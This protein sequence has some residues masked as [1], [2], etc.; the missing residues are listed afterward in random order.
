M[1]E[2]RPIPSTAPATGA[3]EIA[4]LRVVYAGIGDDL[5][6]ERGV[7][8]GW[9]VA[10][11]ELLEA[12]PGDGSVDA[13]VAAFADA[14]AIVTEGLAIT[15]E[16]LE[17]LPRLRAV[18]LQSIGTNTVDLA[19]AAE[20]GVAVS[21]APGFCVDEV[22]THT[23]AMILDLARHV[24]RFDRRVRAGAWDP[25]D[26]SLPMPRRLRGQRVG[27][28][29]FGA[30]PRAVAPLLH[31]FGLEVAVWAPTWSAEDLAAAGVTPVGSLDELLATS[32]VVSLHCPLLPS[33]HHLVGE[34]ELRLMRPS[35]ALVNTAR[36]EVVDE[37]ALVAALRTGTIA[38]AAIDVIEDE[39]SGRTALAELDNVVLTPHSAFLS[40][41]S[42][43]QAREMALA[44]VVDVLVHGRSPRH[45]A[46]LPRTV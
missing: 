34:R 9:G 26:A 8:E 21:H 22:A 17:R 24:T 18:A 35:A 25:L 23:V 37:A 20:R 5:A 6:H 45:E 30:I 29:F 3:P 1:T 10:G 7:L 15:R 11:L 28:V 36:G 4:D 12:D 13:L 2:H 16:V 42:F 46:P 39:D 33:T 31:A 32:D 27:L 14:D 38:A 40:A 44:C 41:E 19:A 43:V